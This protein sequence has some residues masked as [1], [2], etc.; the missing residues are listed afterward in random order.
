MRQS[1][2]FVLVLFFT[3][4]LL[5]AQHAGAPAVPVMA[6]HPA[7]IVPAVPASHLAPLVAVAGAP[8]NS[9]PVT[10]GYR[11]HSSSSGGAVRPTASPKVTGKSQPVPSA[12]VLTS[13]PLAEDELDAPGLGFDY[14]HYAAVHRNSGRHLFG[15]DSVPF[16]GG[17]SYI[18]YPVYLD[19]GAIAEPAAEDATAEIEQPVE[20]TAASPEETPVWSHA[21]SSAPI[22]PESEYVFVRR[23]GTVFFAVAFTFDSTDLRYV[24]QD[25]FRKSIPLASLDLAATQKF[26]EQRGLSPRLPS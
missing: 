20:D 8:A 16:V 25:G 9:R 14:A 3:P 6:A 22:E 21:H 18:P 5:H 7:A 12:P 24:T 23:D 11:V 4:V 2:P 13:A 17:G 10:S 15:G 26:N 1:L 19:N